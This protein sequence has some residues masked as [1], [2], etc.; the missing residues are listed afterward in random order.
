VFLHLECVDWAIRF[1]LLYGRQ[2]VTWKIVQNIAS[3]CCYITLWSDGALNYRLGCGSGLR[4]WK[5]F[6]H[7]KMEVSCYILIN[8][9]LFLIKDKDSV[10]GIATRNGLNGPRIESWWG[11][12]FP[13][14]SRPT[15]GPTQPAGQWVPSH[16]R[17]EMASTT[18][19][20][21]AP[22]LESE[23]SC[24]FFPPC[25]VVFGI[26]WILPFLCPSSL[27]SQCN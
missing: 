17:G 10:V 24:T 4:I 12:G 21:L 27:H 14:L 26:G 7:L 22:R 5:W 2:A 20:H 11:W 25:T 3:K 6:L 23:W 15:Q 9:V 18:H 19:C 8:S 16:S 1:V 13:H